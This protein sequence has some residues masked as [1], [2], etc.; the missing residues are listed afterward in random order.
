MK[1]KLLLTTLICTSLFGYAQITVSGTVTAKGKP[2]KN[3]AVTLKDT[4]D[5][6]TTNDKG[7]FTFTTTEHGDQVLTFTAPDFKDEEKTIK[8]ADQNITQDI[9]LK[10]SIGDIE[11]VTLTS[12]SISSLGKKAS[13]TL[14]KPLDYVTTPGGE[15]QISATLGFLPGVQKVEGSTGMFVRG[16]TSTETKAFIDGN[17]VNNYYFNTL[18]GM[19]GRDRFNSAIF[20]NTDFSR[21]AY[22]ALY[23]EALSSVL[24]LESVDLPEKSSGTLTLLPIL[25]SGSYQHVNES[26][27]ASYGASLGMLNM[28]WFTKLMN[29]QTKFDKGPKGLNGDLNFRIKTK[30]GGFLK[31]FGN[32]DQNTVG[33]TF[34]VASSDFNGM[35]F[36]LKAGNTYHNLSFKQKFGTYLLNVGTSLSYNKN[37]MTQTLLS[38]NGNNMQFG[39][40]NHGTYVNAKAVLEKK[41]APVTV[42]GGVEL[43]NAIEDLTYTNAG[44]TLFKKHYNNAMTSIFAESDWTIS[45]RFNTQLG[46]RAENSSYLEKW[47]LAPRAAFGYRLSKQWTAILS[48]G[49]FYQM[50]DSQYLNYPFPLNFQRADHYNFQI[51]KITPLQN[52]RFEAFYKDYRKLTKTQDFVNPNNL[53]SYNTFPTAVNVN[54]NG[55]AKG[56][57]LFWRDAKTIKGID[58]WVSYTYLDSE[59]NFNNYPTSLVPT[60]V[61]KHTVSI[62]AKRYFTAW[63]TQ[64]N[65]AYTYTSGRPYYDLITQNG[66]GV[67]RNQGHLQDYGSLNF[68]L[69][70]LP[71]M[72]KKDANSFMVFFLSAQNVL[73]KKNIPGYNF[74]TTGQAIA[75]KPMAYTTFNIGFIINFGIDRT[76]DAINNN[77]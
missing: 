75:Q 42:R 68:S 14:L 15:G 16:G 45:S 66:Q 23:G 74:S 32:F 53:S 47:N 40:E 35:K 12:E 61:A 36:G 37:E 48:Y 72:G 18:E 67:L 64:V 52:F 59:R 30:G 24:I 69:N 13:K 73:N 5:G 50:P 22:S 65:A 2:V 31:Y 7:Q 10:A 54:G 25:A 58:Y 11:G 1:T 29:Y 4:Y 46:V 57:E 55:Y 44:T 19:G 56:M 41:I 20:K 28:N 70:Y 21:G 49:M 27:A 6:A 77:L 60:F 39:N 71:N 17:L 34:P 51:Q 62:V 63:K 43:Q 9:T 8:I 76:Q 3:V 26:R 38:S 33:T